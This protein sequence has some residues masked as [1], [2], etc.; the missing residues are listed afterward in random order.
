[1]YVC[2]SWP[3]AFLPYPV[4]RWAFFTGISLLFPQQRVKDIAEA[5]AALV[6][7]NLVISAAD[8]ATAAAHHGPAD[9]LGPM[10]LLLTWEDLAPRV[11]LRS[12]WQH[13]YRLGFQ[14]LRLGTFKELGFN[15]S[16]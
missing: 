9:V 2:E 4:W 13:E 11:L 15:C 8:Q 5:I 16:C 1:M 6:H 10:L 3:C 14:D 7:S 12:V